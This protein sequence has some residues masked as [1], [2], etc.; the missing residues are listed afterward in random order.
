[1]TQAANIRGQKWRL[2]RCNGGT[3]ELVTMMEALVE[4][5]DTK[6]LTTTTE[7]LAEEV[8]ETTCL[9]KRLKWRRWRCVYGP[10]ELK[11]TTAALEE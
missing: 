7:A 5:D 6:N 4:E 11:T 9:S 3:E 8:E 1:M 2:E 10:S